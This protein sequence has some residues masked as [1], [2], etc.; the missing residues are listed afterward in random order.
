M[1]KLLI[2]LLLTG[3]AT[4]LDYETLPPT[5]FQA[6]C[7]GVEE[8]YPGACD[9]LAE[10]IY[11]RSWIV[12]S[13]VTALVTSVGGGQLRGLYYDGEPY[14]YVRN[15]LSPEDTREVLIHESVHYIVSYAG[16]GLDKCD[17][18]E[19]AF[20]VAKGDAYSDEWRPG[21]GCVEEN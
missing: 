15:D 12:E 20:R 17:N 2:A 7:A 21:Y 1:K 14:V 3:C 13:T 6:A 18:E 4:T 16:L 19:L 10:P 9:N 5:P 8:F 11:V